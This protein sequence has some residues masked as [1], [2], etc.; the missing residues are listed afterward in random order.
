MLIPDLLTFSKPLQGRDELKQ[1]LANLW[2]DTEGK[3]LENWLEKPSTAV[4]QIADEAGSVQNLSFPWSQRKGLSPMAE[5]TFTALPPK[6]II[7][8]NP[9]AAAFQMG[10]TVWVQLEVRR[11]ARDFP[12]GAVVKNPPANAGDM[13]SSPGPGRSHMPRS[14]KAHAPQL[15]NPARLQPVL[16][17][18]SHRNEKPAHHNEE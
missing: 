4:P 12:G 10:K 13:G 7:S 17:K 1:E 6:S 18:R 3:S 8:G 15:L 9:K 5:T 11:S 16:H 14:N 2:A